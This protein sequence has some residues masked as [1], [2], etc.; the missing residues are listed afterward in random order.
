MP[1]QLLFT[2]PPIRK[3]DVLQYQ[4]PSGEWLDY[5]TIKDEEN[6]RLSLRMAKG[7]WY[8]DNPIQPYRIKMQGG[9]VFPTVYTLKTD[10]GT[11][12]PVEASNLYEA[13]G[14]AVMMAQHSDFGNAWLLSGDTTICYVAKL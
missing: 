9:E 7:E 12:H 8:G 5:N 6:A 1:E 3:Y 2:N 4:R 11:I 10:D 14:V 13:I